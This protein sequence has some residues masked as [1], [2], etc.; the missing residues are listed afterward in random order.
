MTA[1]YVLKPLLLSPSKNQDETTQ[2]LEK[3][4]AGVKNSNGK[5]GITL[6]V[7]GYVQQHSF[8]PKRNYGYRGWAFY[9]NHTATKPFNMGIAQFGR[10]MVNHS[11]FWS[12]SA[13]KWEY[14]IFRNENLRYYPWPTFVGQLGSK[15]MSK[16]ESFSLAGS[17]NFS[18]LSFRNH[19]CCERASIWVQYNII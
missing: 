18:S 17:Q 19:K 13:D 5:S 4:R 15:G 3:A 16:W 10:V 9:Y 6:T 2:C 8:P 11:I 14:I 1:V 7:Y 12:L